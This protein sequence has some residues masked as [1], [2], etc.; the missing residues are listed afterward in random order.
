[1]IAICDHNS[2]GNVAAVQEAAGDELAVIAGIEI[3]TAEEVH[4]LG[5]FPGAW[6][7]RAVG[8][9]VRA[10]LPEATEASARFGE[11]LL[12]DVTGEVVGREGKLLAAASAF[13]LDEAIALIHRRS[14][15]AVAS[16]VDRP[17]FGVIGQLG[18]FPA[19]ARF[20]AIEVSAAGAAA[21]RAA[22]FAGLGLPLVTG[23]DSHCLSEVGAGRT[24]FEL[25]EPTFGELAL[26]FRGLAGRRCRRA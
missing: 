22:E 2:A 5:L 8:D 23:S 26:A 9:E 11:Q 21:G 3:T 10:T 13:G 1:M 4:V 7:A 20:D 12:L 16:H 25:L 19:D 24:V 18:I 17:A 6:A 15:L 14:G